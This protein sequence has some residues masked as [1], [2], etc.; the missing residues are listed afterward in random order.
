M[1]TNKM[2]IETVTQLRLLL[3]QYES[4]TCVGNTRKTR[5]TRKVKLSDFNQ[6]DDIAPPTNINKDPIKSYRMQTEYGP[7]KF[8]KP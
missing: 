3:N 8:I 5:N 4:N 6:T 7:K 2:S 1:E